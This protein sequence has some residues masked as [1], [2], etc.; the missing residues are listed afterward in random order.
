MKRLFLVLF[1]FITL[2]A[3][4]VHKPTKEFT[5]LAM[6]GNTIVKRSVERGDDIYSGFLNKI[7]EKNYLDFRTTDN[8]SGLKVGEN[9]TIRFTLDIPFPGLTGKVGDPYSAAR[10]TKI[11]GS[12]TFFIDEGDL[13]I[14]KDL[15]NEKKIRGLEKDN[16]Y[17]V[18]FTVSNIPSRWQSWNVE[19][20]KLLLPFGIDLKALIKQ[21]ILVNTTKKEIKG[22]IYS[23]EQ[24]HIVGLHLNFTYEYAKVEYESLLKKV[25]II[26]P[27]KYMKDKASRD[28]DKAFAAINVIFSAKTLR[29]QEKSFLA[30]INALKNIIYYV[31]QMGLD[32]ANFKTLLT[33][34]KSLSRQVSQK[35]LKLE[36]VTPDLNKLRQDLIK[37]FG[38]LYNKKVQK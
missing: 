20:P 7:S 21:N 25:E 38:K 2:H 37:L 24:C 36:K 22:S 31:E 10:L 9:D 13:V 4:Q 32:A 23:I 8:P 15:A 12:I 11:A 19:G 30:L 14:V 28:L 27:F 3:Q 1:V 33:K 18:H 35:K 17:Q 5:T 26:E 34:A 6:N 16:Y 29:G